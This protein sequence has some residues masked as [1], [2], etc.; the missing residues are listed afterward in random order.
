MA[1]QTFRGVWSI[2]ALHAPDVPISL[3]QAW[4]QDAYDE[5]IGR[6]HW[7]WTRR[8][9]VLTTLAQRSVTPT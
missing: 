5:L 4:T 8:Q 1:A 6:R 3:V 2:V 7:G 9:H